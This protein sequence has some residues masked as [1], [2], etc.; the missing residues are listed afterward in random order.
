VKSPAAILF[1]LDDTLYDYSEFR[2]SGFRAVSDHLGPITGIAP[3]PLYRK[4]LEIDA[5]RVPFHPNAFDELLRSFD[6]PLR[7]LDEMIRVFRNH[8]P[9]I[10]PFPGVREM[11]GE[12]DA[13][14]GIPLYLVTE[15]HKGTQGRKIQ[16]LG[17]G[18][19]FRKIFILEP[20]LESKEKT[21][22]Y[23]EIRRS[24]PVH[25][26]LL[27]VIGDNPAKDFLLPAR[28]GM[29]LVQVTGGHGREDV[30]PR[31]HF[32]FARAADLPGLLD[33]TAKKG[34]GECTATE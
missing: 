34:P 5:S 21:S 19:F 18:N 12:L 24:V 16:A 20:P 30:T 2:R 7:F 8:D 11:L 17:V 29:T 4:S 14:R 23:E 13:K 6:L 22:V 25:P 3:G 28:M 1:D 31:P 32:R 33:S 10:L 15:G 27:W 9:E 26:S